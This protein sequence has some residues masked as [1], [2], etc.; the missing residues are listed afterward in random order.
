MLGLIFLVSLLWFQIYSRNV[1]CEEALNFVTIQSCLFNCQD[2]HCIQRNMSN[3]L[4]YIW[5]ICGGKPTSIRGVLIEVAIRW[6]SYQ[7]TYLPSLFSLLDKFIV[8]QQKMDPAPDQGGRTWQPF[9]G[10]KNGHENFRQARF[11]N[12]CDKCVVFARIR[13]FA[14]L[15]QWNMQYIP[16]NSALLA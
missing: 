2:A 1:C 3:I 14:N 7:L 9:V 8:R 11:Y 15:T 5:N 13:K 4:R 12:F 6:S 16:C 10:G